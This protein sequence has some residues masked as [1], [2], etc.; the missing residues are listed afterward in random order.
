MKEQMAR[1]NYIYLAFNVLDTTVAGAWTVKHEMERAIEG[2]ED[3]YY[4]F[5]VK[6]GELNPKVIELD[7]TNR[8][9]QAKL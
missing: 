5:R 2:R 4:C 3:G 7:L 8:N 1:S 9:N 6:D